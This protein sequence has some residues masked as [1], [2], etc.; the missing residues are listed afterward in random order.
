MKLYNTIIAFDCY[1]FAESE[2]AAIDA[3]N[4]MIKSG[5]V[6]GTHRK[7]LEL[8]ASPVRK[9]WQDERPLVAADVSDADFE[10]LR[11]KT[12]QQ[13]HEMLTTR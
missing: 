1:V 3:L 10:R 13:A 6:G 4:E 5:E 2:G 11:G 12:I 8:R 9:E 7:A